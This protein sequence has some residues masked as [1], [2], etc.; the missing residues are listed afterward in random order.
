M[1]ELSAGFLSLDFSGICPSLI[2]PATTAPGAPTASTVPLTKEC[3]PKL[4][5]EDAL[6]YVCIDGKWTSTT[7]ITQDIFE[8]PPQTTIVIVG[9]LTTSQ[10]V[11]TGLQASVIVKGCISDDLEYVSVEITEQDIKRLEKEKGKKFTH[12]LLSVDSSGNSTELCNNQINLAS[13]QLKPRLK[14]VDARRS[15][16]RD[17][18]LIKNKRFRPSSLSIP[19]SA[20]FDGSF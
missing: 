9:N 5:A 10:L 15:K 18:N 3:L 16:L 4:S 20:T 1:E 2:P 11:L 19:P 7:S 12:L 17:R 6:R 14:K 8:I 13:V